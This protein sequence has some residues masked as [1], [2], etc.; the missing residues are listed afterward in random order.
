MTPKSKLETKVTTMKSYKQAFTLIELLVVIAIIAILAAILFPVFA[1]AKNAAN[2]ASDLS[3]TKQIGLTIHM[4][5]ADHDDHVPIGRADHYLEWTVPRTNGSRMTYNTRG[6]W[7]VTLQ[8]Y[9]RNKEILISPTKPSM[10]GIPIGGS[11]SGSYGA[12]YRGFFG[13]RAAVNMG[14]HEYPA[15]LIAVTASRRRASDEVPC[16]NNPNS[17]SCFGYYA[18]TSTWYNYWYNVR[19]NDRERANVVFGDSHAKALSRGEIF[20]PDELPAINTNESGMVISAGTHRNLSDAQLEFNMRRWN[21][22]RA[23][24]RVD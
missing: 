9:M 2:N 20:G 7:Y 6:Y 15:E 13:R 8:P 24:G 4:Y 3:N 14:L 10:Y 23:D 17:S 11:R 5:A 21:F 12:N 1:Q 19:F 22:P 16:S 18:V